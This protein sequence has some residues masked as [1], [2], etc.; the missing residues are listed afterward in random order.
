VSTA[1]HGGTA[2]RVRAGSAAETAERHRRLAAGTLPL[3]NLPKGVVGA[4][5]VIRVAAA[6]TLGWFKSPGGFWWDAPEAH[7]ASDG[8]DAR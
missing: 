4:T 1:P 8:I 2:D 3:P 6:D 5:V 7:R